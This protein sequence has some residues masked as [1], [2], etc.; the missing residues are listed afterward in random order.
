MKIFLYV[1]NGNSFV[2]NSNFEPNPADHIRKPSA[3]SNE[4]AI[5]I[6]A[7]LW[8]PGWIVQRYIFSNCFRL[9]NMHKMIFQ[10]N[11]WLKISSH[12]IALD[13]YGASECLFMSRSEHIRNTSNLGN[14]FSGWAGRQQGMPTSFLEQH[15]LWSFFIF[16]SRL[17]HIML[18]Q[19]LPILNYSMLPLFHCRNKTLQ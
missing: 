2:E 16:S 13:G 19:L 14:W 3:W 4:K 8:L 15:V 18:I 9:N 5:L 7:F 1:P 11:M 12:G 6:L 17:G 10:Q